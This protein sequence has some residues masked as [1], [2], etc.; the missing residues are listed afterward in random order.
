MRRRTILRRVHLS[1][2]LLLIIGGPLRA[3]ERLWVLLAPSQAEAV[4]RFCSRGPVAKID[5]GWQPTTKNIDAMEEALSKSTYLRGKLTS[6]PDQ[7]SNPRQYYRQYVGVI[8][9]GRKLIYING[10]CGK[11]PSYWTKTLVDV[12]DGGRC[13]WGA[14]YDPGSGEFSQ[15]EMNGVA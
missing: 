13:F 4:S 10:M 8:V 12:C 11:P 6:K 9:A 14:L 2:V 7:A 15:F 5:G 1:L 3:D